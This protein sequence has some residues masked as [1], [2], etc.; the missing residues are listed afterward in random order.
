[1]CTSN[2]ASQHDTIALQG[3]SSTSN[4]DSNGNVRMHEKVLVYAPLQ[5]VFSIVLILLI[6]HHLLVLLLLIQ[7]HL[8]LCTSDYETSVNIVLHV[9]CSVLYSV[10]EC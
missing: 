10:D 3:N 2:I 6:V 7:T 9:I 4:C 8:G 1:V 5:L